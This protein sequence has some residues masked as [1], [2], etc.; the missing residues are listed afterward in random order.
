VKT[1]SVALCIQAGIALWCVLC[2]NRY[3]YSHPI[4]LMGDLYRFAPTASL[5]LLAAVAIAAHRQKASEGEFCVLLFISFLLLAMTYIASTMML[6][7]D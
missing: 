6:V 5:V 7:R 3:I 4:A 2:F 1:T